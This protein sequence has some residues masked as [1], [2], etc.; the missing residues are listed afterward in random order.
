VT[1]VSSHKVAASHQLL[2]LLAV[3]CESHT[4]RVGLGC[5][6]INIMCM[7]LLL[8]LLLVVVVVF[9]SAMLRLL[10]REAN[11]AD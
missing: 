11:H 8:L 6:I 3:V 5:L 7:Y 2:L 10:V 9:L 1:A 4:D